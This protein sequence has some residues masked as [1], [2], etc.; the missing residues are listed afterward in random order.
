MVG[1]DKILSKC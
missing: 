1:V